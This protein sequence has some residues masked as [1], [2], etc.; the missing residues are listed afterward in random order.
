M[1]KLNRHA[2]RNAISRRA[3]GP[4]I[5]ALSV[6][7]ADVGVTAAKASVRDLWTRSDIGSAEKIATEIPSHGSALYLVTPL[8]GA[9][10]Y[11]R[12]VERRTL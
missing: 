6:A 5:H 10:K 3:C 8:G 7:L 2:A 12:E 4:E 1:Q 9:G 11:R